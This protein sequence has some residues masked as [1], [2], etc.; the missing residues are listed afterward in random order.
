M[1]LP[2]VSV[3]IPV[4]NSE[5]YLVE[6]IESIINQTY[7][8]LEIL[9]IDDLSTDDSWKIIEEYGKIDARIV[10]V[11]N[12]VNLNSAATRNVG[13]K[14]AHGK[15]ICLHDSD[16]VSEPDRIQKQVNYLESHPDVHA[17]GS[18][19]LIIDCYSNI[20]GKRDYPTYSK[21]IKKVMLLFDPI[22]QPTIMIERNLFDKVG[23]YNE[24]YSRAQDYDLWFRILEKY[25]IDNLNEY[26]VRYR[27]HSNQGLA[28][29]IRCNFKF[30]LEIQRQHIFDK[31]FF[32]PLGLILFPIKILLVHLPIA[33]QM[34]L[35]NFLFYKM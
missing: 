15:Y 26:L 23:Y 30:T 4:F 28:Q 12:K 8:N 18:N 3:V 34:K 14:K 19:M 16:D 32:N 2:L 10:P 22:A 9:I 35:V 21:D 17:L 5:K 11:K 1:D 20:I 7:S 31:Q 6:S 24:K 33:F 13:I 27:R 29:K 25:N